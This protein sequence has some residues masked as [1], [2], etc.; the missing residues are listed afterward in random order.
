[1]KIAD[2]F[3]YITLCIITILAIFIHS[4]K[5]DIYFPITAFD[6]VEYGIYEKKQIAI[7]SHSIKSV[8]LAK[9]DNENYLVTYLGG[10]EKEDSNFYGILFRPSRYSV[11]INGKWQNI[12]ANTQTWGIPKLL[13]TQQSLLAQIN[14]N[15]YTFGFPIMQRY[16]DKLY[17]LLNGRNFKNI[18]TS[19]IHI[20]HANANEVLEYL[21]DTQSSNDTT[22]FHFYKRI[23][24][25]LVANIN[26]FLSKNI[27][28]ASNA[29]VENFI[30]P[31]YAKFRDY[32][33]LFGIFDSEFVLQE[34]VKPHNLSY[35]SM[36][37]MT[38]I[39]QDDMFENYVNT[40]NVINNSHSCLVVYHNQSKDKQEKEKLYFQTCETNNGTLLFDTLQTSKNIANAQY[41][42]MATLGKSVLLAYTNQDSTAL[43]L[44][45]W[46]GED[47][48]YLRQIEEYVK[49]KI[50]NPN[51][52]V[53][54]MYAYIIYNSQI[55]KH[56]T[57]ITL[58]ESY[59][60]SLI[61]RNTIL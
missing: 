16:N 50:V 54:G 29:N 19:R 5:F 61:T 55:K 7:D 15:M 51:I 60:K 46:N 10:E 31:F 59:I 23:I 49:D 8:N 2:S 20:F 6:T 38:Q 14:Q 30:I 41:L 4:T 9:I 33:A 25:G 17:L 32:I 35:L 53:N 37:I 26:Y 57:I 28:F 39:P 1:M 48:V 18:A 58:D 44:A 22:F 40:D 56:I 3:F 13:A 42:S 12:T 24:V 43:N 52:I 27:F 34:A 11:P 45:V 36:P 21:Q 47:F